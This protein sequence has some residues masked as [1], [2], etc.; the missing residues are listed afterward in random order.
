MRVLVRGP[1]EAA[2]VALFR[3][4]AGIW[5]RGEGRIVRPPL[6]AI[7]FLPQQPYLTPG[8]LRHLLVR[9]EQE[10]E[11]SDNAFWLPSATAGSSPL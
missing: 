2:R 11:I 10:T 1:N 5:V 4:T 7:F 3:A 8:T 6:D 9:T